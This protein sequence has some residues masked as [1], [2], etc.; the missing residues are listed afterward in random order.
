MIRR[1]ADPRVIPCL[2]RLPVERRG[3]E[4]VTIWKCEQLK[5]LKNKKD[6]L[7][8]TFVFIRQWCFDDS[9]MMFSYPQRGRK[10]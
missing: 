6:Q 5:K 3:V 8:S 1:E 2:R 9:A 4:S 7:K 10:V